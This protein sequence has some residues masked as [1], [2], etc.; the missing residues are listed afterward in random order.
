MKTSVYLSIFFSL[1]ASC[2]GQSPAS[3]SV[4]F[5]VYALRPLATNNLYYQDSPESFTKLEFR[6]KSR[7]DIYQASIPS[8]NQSLRIY[9]QTIST[10]GETNY[11]LAGQTTLPQS[12]TPWLVI[13]TN[14]P[15]DSNTIKAYAVDDSSISYPKGSM[16]LANITGVEVVGKINDASVT[17]PSSQI[18]QAFHGGSREA[19]DIAIAAEGNSRYHLLY[20]NT[21]RITSGSRGLLLLTPPVRKGS[22]RIGG[23]LLLESPNEVKTAAE[24]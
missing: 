2:W 10:N 19:F 1:L 7:S 4:N 3:Y 23:H 13:L 9:R 12:Q 15:S 18:S 6:P 20:K 21:V 22:I 17:L 16:R 14:N 5:S 24:L 8:H 11:Q